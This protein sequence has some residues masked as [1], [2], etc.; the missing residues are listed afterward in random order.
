MAAHLAQS[1]EHGT[2]RGAALGYLIFAEDL[3]AACRESLTES[4]ASGVVFFGAAQSE[5]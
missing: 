2:P 3:I 4:D 1:P 5:V